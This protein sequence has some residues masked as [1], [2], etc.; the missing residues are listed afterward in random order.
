MVMWFIPISLLVITTLLAIP[1]SRYAAWIMNGK[2]RAPKVLHWFE[3]K[4]DSGPQNW[5]Q[6]ALSLLIFNVIL[7]IYGFA[8]LWLQGWQHLP[9][10]GLGRGML[11]PS[12]I[13][14]SVISFMTNTN[15]QHYSGDQHLSNFSQIF[16]CIANQFLS[17]AVGFCALSAIIRAFRSD[18]DVGNF[19]VDMWRVVVY[20]FL[21]PAL[22][23]VGI[24][25]H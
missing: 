17:A 13:F 8:V 22:I 20:M 14:N 7:F 6:Y 3:A 10:N 1:L 16:F 4:L 11:A 21:P 2:Y 5:I 12:T 25:L 18:P 19:F 23:L 15:L 24:F 9:L